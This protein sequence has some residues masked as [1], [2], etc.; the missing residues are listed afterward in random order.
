MPRL[1][2]PRPRE[3]C[4]GTGADGASW[5]RCR[6]NVHRSHPGDG[7]RRERRRPGLRAQGAEHAGGPVAR[8]HPGRPRNLR[9]GRGQAG[10]HRADRS[11]HDHRDEHGDRIL[12]RR[13]R[14]AH[15][16]GLPRHPAH[17]AAQAAA[18]FLHAVRRALAVAPAGQAAQP[19]P[20]HRA[21][22]AAGRPHRGRARRGRGARRRRAPEVARGGL[23]HRLLP[24]RLPERRARAARQGDRE[25]G[26]AGGLRRLLVRGGRRDPGVRALL[27]GGDERLH[28]PAHVL[29]PEQS[30]D[31]AHGEWRRRPD[32]RDAVQRRRDHFGR[33][34]RAPGDDPHVGARRRRH[35]RA[36]GGRHVGR[37]QLDYRRYRR[38]VGGHQRCAGRRGPHH[39]PA[40][41]AGRRLSDPGPP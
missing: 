11:R 9:R 25:G 2:P 38:H 41:H 15:H 34:R 7:R 39:E 10:R 20:H 18:Q 40:R 5:C 30:G 32:S 8:G 37:P 24:V 22:S 21:H 26:D 35:R 16:A 6:G 14:H 28:R 13:G 31:G 19:H 36:V 1:R 23:G 3:S 17:G 4:A 12:R 33:R 27:D 29:L